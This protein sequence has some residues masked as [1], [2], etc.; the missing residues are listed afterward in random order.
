MENIILN[1]Q[2]ASDI[3]LEHYS[4]IM[5]ETILTP[6]KNN[7]LGLLGDIG[8]PKTE[9]YK[10]FIYWCSQNFHIV[11]LISGNHEYYG[12]DIKTTDQIIESIANSLNNVF[13]LN[14]KGL[15]LYNKFIILGTTLWSYVREEYQE[16]ISNNM[17]DYKYI[18]DLTITDTNN[19]FLENFNFLNKY[20]QEYRDKYKIIILSHHTPS[21]DKTSS[22]KYKNSLS[23][24]AFST[25]INTEG[26]HTWCYGHT[27]YNNDFMKNN[28][29]I[30]SNQRGYKD[31]ILCNYKKDLTI[32]IY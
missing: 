8:D 23:N 28:T 15:I 6:N 31:K 19:L 13:Y 14:N 5:F 32:N 21:I 7:I 2:I 20:V 1:L 25:E 30:I 26:I 9:L 16:Y 4:N 11:L 18:K 3:H 24:Y 27:H 29:R 22:P 12:S 17:N 10:Q